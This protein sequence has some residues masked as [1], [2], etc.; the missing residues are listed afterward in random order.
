MSSS[1]A[2]GRRAVRGAR[3]DAEVERYLGLTLTERKGKP[4][5]VAAPALA[6]VSVD[7][8]R[9]QIRRPAAAAAATPAAADSAPP[10]EEPLPPD[11][12]HRGKPKRHDFPPIIPAP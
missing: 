3:R 6:V 9:L 7:G 2:A 4:A 11:D 5:G 12:K 1:Y 10:P 8:G